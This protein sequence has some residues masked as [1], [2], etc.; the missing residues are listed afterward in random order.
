MNIDFRGGPYDGLR[1]T[2]SQVLRCTSP[3]LV[4][5]DDGVRFFALMPRP[6]DWAAV[7]AGSRASDGQY[8]YELVLTPGVGCG[9]E[10]HDA[11]EDGS[12]DQIVAVGRIV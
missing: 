6:A 12:F 5:V 11:V 9:A 7:F 4:D 2:R 3:L 1:L 10:F 8:P